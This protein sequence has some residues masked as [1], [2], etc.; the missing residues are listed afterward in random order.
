MSLEQKIE[1]LNNEKIPQ[2]YEAGQK[3]MVDESKVIEKT[4]N[5]TGFVNIDDVSE[6]PH[7]V[8]VQLSSDTITDFSNIEVTVCGKNLLDKDNLILVKTYNGYNFYSIQ[9][10]AGNIVTFSYSQNIESGLNMYVCANTQLSTPNESKLWLYHKT[11]TSSTN[12][13]VTITANDT[14]VVYLIISLEGIYL[15]KKYLG[16]DLQVELGSNT[17][18]YESFKGATYTPNPDGTVNIKS[19]SPIMNISTNETD[20]NL[21]VNYHK[22]YGK[23]TAYDE[24]WDSYQENG[25]RTNYIAGFGGEGWTNKTFKPKYDITPQYADNL[26]QS[27]R[28]INLKQ[29][30]IDCGVKLDMSGTKQS[31]YFL[32][33]AQITVMPEIDTTGM[34]N[35]TSL[36]SHAANLTTITKL[37]L[38][39]DGSQVAS[40]TFTGATKIVTMIVEGTIG[41]N[42]DLSPCTKLSKESITSVIN[43]L[44]DTTTSMKL[45]LSKT[46]VNTAFGINVDDTTTYPEGSEYYTLRHSK[47][48]WTISYI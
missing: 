5:G 44:F 8:E 43:A 13:K 32:R 15:F 30:L 7:K 33:S 36:F 40:N 16:N 42:F 19:I 46:A 41:Q 25:T 27:S 17:T 39:D 22:S 21:S 48:N 12:K 20:I 34:T 24:F 29:A 31:Q 38:K 47:D 11:S 3:S 23:Q 28:I 6:I 9:V 10:G 14:G 2:V 18:S 37:I 26:F 1:I 4:V 45:T 35:I